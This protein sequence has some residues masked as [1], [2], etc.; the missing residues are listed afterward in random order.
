M[1][2]AKKYIVLDVSATTVAFFSKDKMQ[3]YNGVLL[4]TCPRRV[5]KLNLDGI[6]FLSETIAPGVFLMAL[7]ILYVIVYVWQR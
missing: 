5:I 6:F 1:T 4:G 7:K 3:M 2:L